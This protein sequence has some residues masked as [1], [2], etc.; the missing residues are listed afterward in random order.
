MTDLSDQHIV[1]RPRMRLRDLLEA[2][3]Y[4]LMAWIVCGLAGYG[5]YVI[6]QRIFK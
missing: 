4:W 2:G 1:N 5:L 3:C 6:G